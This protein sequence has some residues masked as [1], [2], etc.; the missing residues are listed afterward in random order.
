MH[1]NALKRLKMRPQSVTILG[2]SCLSKR[3][4]VILVALC[5]ASSL[6][7]ETPS[8]IFSV[9]SALGEKAIS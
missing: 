7:E 8:H 5:K 4:R 3:C 6:K 2:L 9:F 1:R